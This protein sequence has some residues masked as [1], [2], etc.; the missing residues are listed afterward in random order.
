[1]RTV[2]LWIISFLN[3]EIVRDLLGAI[4]NYA[5]D[6]CA[7][8]RPTRRYSVFQ[9]FILISPNEFLR[10]LAVLLA[11]GLNPQCNIKCFW[12]HVDHEYKPG[13]Q[14][15]CLASDLKH[16]SIAFSTQLEQTQSAK[17]KLSPSSTN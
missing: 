6:L 3:K 4:N 9:N 7:K 13:T 12:S 1:M 8:N 15:S 10:F 14:R 16:C 17:K 5:A 11:M 2:V